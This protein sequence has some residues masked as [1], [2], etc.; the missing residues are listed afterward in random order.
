[1]HNMLGS[2]GGRKGAV[3]NNIHYDPISGTQSKYWNQN[4]KVHW[5][6][7]RLPRIA[8]TAVLHI[9][10]EKLHYS[11]LRGSEGS[12]AD[13][14]RNTFVW[15]TVPVATGKESSLQFVVIESSGMFFIIWILQIFWYSVWLE[16]DSL[17]DTIASAK[18][19][20]E[21]SFFIRPAIVTSEYR[22]KFK[23]HGTLK[24]GQVHERSKKVGAH[25][26]RFA[27]L[28]CLYMLEARS[29]WEPNNRLGDEHQGAKQGIH[30]TV[31]EKDVVARFVFR[32]RP[33]CACF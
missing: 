5:R 12:F 27:S 19:L 22:Q 31:K 23:V 4:F 6:D 13:S 14:A 3:N 25:R 29:H 24:T 9:D 32:Y 10:G 8:A 15:S 30:C 1:M 26:T 21:I 28:I 16:D 17:E 2:F 20:G 18:N 11:I 33:I 7:T